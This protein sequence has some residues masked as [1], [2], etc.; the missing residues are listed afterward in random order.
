MK[1]VKEQLA[2]LLMAYHNRLDNNDQEWEIKKIMVAYAPAGSGFDSGTEIDFD[3]SDNSRLVFNTS[4][5]HMTD[6]GVYDGWTEHTITVK[7]GF[8]FD[9]IKVS[10]KNKNNIKEYIVETFGMFIDTEVTF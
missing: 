5:H 4:F 2:A 1:T 7:P 10:G 6:N 3:R 9:V 8:Y